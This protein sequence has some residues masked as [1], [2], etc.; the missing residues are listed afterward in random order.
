MLRPGGLLAFSHSTPLDA[1]CWDEPSQTMPAAAAASPT[2]ACTAEDWTEFVTFNL[3]Y[4]AAGSSS[5]A[6]TASAS[7]T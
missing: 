6:P 7:R 5:S 1:L 3:P 2:S 4:G